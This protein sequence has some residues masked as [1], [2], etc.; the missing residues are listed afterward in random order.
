MLLLK[1]KNFI[2]FCRISNFHFR[3]RKEDL[4][5]PPHS[6]KWLLSWTRLS[7]PTRS[8][9]KPPL[10]VSAFKFSRFFSAVQN[11]YH[12]CFTLNY[13]LTTDLSFYILI[14][15]STFT[16]LYLYLLLMYIYIYLKY[17]HLNNVMI[18]KEH[19]SS[20]NMCL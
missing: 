6:T 1:F 2:C 7:R 14:K 12:I 5:M 10:D 20:S 19:S 15:Q 17:L 3:A 8:L 16:R 11:T 9:T 4:W 13:I 18:R